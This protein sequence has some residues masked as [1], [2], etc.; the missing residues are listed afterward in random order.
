MVLF[1]GMG[2]EVAS[3][4]ELLHAVKIFGPS[5]IVFDSPAKTRKD[6]EIAIEKGVILN[7]DNLQEIEVIAKVLQGKS[8]Q[9]VQV[10]LRINPQTGAGT[11]AS[12]STATSTSKFGYAIEHKS[13]IIQN[14]TKYSWLK[15]LR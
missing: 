11:I 12:T 8:S 6:I 1:V 9:N 7:A 4:P 3:L 5:K 14:F 10:G 2:C 13:E 15:G